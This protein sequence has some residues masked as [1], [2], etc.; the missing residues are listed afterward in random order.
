MSL[1]RGF[2]SSSKIPAV[3]QSIRTKAASI[4][5][6]PKVIVLPEGWD[7]RTLEAASM[8]ANANIARVILLGDDP[9]KMIS[10]GLVLGEH[11]SKMRWI[12]PNNKFNDFEKMIE[13]LVQIRKKKNISKA[14]ATQALSCPLLFGNMLVRMGLANGNVCGAVSTSA[15]VARAALVAIGTKGNNASSFFVMTREKNSTR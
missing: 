8:A 12:P 6:R 10:D 15:D 3:L 11:Q 5:P 4:I 1:A 13:L 2:A 9:K 7:K 14:K